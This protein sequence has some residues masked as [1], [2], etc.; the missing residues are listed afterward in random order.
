MPSVT[1]ILTFNDPINVSVQVGDIVYYVDNPNT[2]GSVDPTSWDIIGNVI[3][4]G[5]IQQ[6]VNQYGQAGAPYI[7]VMSTLS[8]QNP[9]SGSAFIMFGKDK[10]ANTS[11]LIGYYARV[12]F[13][14]NSKEKA[15]LFS[16]GSEIFESI[17]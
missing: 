3:Q 4:F 17:K 15:E 1:Y 16:V 14:N 11:S 8:P 12:N 9:P 2:S 13:V 10:T 6:I 5:I 7:Q